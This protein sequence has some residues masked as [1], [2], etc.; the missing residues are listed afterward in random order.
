MQAR[1]LDVR[2]NTL[3]TSESVR[4]LRCWQMHWQ[5]RMDNRSQVRCV[6]AYR[7]K[8]NLHVRRELYGTRPSVSR[9]GAR[10]QGR[11]ERAIRRLSKRC[12]RRSCPEIQASV[13]FHCQVHA[14]FPEVDVH[15]LPRHHKVVLNVAPGCFVVIPCP[16][17]R[18]WQWAVAG[19]PSGRRWGGCSAGPCGETRADTCVSQRQG[20]RP[21]S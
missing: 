14:S 18:Q 12:E 20:R 1:L 6:R 3:P 13:T 16:I 5:I 2:N 4:K 7:L 21:G 11:T 19:R 9:E 17:I 15:E 10:H 8:R